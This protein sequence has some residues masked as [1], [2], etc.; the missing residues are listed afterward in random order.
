MTTRTAPVNSRL[1]MTLL[2]CCALGVVG[3]GLLL[4]ANP[5][6]Q[7]SLTGMEAAGA[8]VAACAAALGLA[9]LEDRVPMCLLISIGSRQHV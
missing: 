4:V 5:V 2:G 1:A 9:L 8:A 6:P 7:L 3:L